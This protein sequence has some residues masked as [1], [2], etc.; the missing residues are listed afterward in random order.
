MDKIEKRKLYL[1]HL[2]EINEGTSREKKIA[3][4]VHKIKDNLQ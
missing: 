2:E 3:E 4:A 1:K